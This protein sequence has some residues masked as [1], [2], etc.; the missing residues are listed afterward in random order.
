MI[1]AVTRLGF[2][3]RGM[4]FETAGKLL[5]IRDYVFCLVE[6][7]PEKETS[8]QVRAL[9]EELLNDPSVHQ[10]IRDWSW[11]TRNQ[12]VRRVP[13]DELRER[14]ERFLRQARK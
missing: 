13:R 14:C 6:R 8:K 1:A 7:T 3:A 12:E 5:S 9:L 10:A 2:D 4:D 11:H